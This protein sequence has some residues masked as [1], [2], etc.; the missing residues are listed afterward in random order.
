M[1]PEID[2]QG[3]RLILSI[4]Q[5]RKA[6]KLKETSGDYPKFGEFSK[7]MSRTASDVNDHV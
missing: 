5:K 1:L 4:L 6:L 3:S 2:T 7:F